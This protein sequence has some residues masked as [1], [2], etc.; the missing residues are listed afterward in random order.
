[1]NR[2]YDSRGGKAY[3]STFDIRMRGTGQYAELLAQRFHLAMKKLA[4][5]GSPILNASLFRP[6]PMSGQMDLFD[7]D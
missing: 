6:K 1:M 7:C 4:F 5:P 2:I 3:D